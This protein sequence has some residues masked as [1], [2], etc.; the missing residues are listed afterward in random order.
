MPMLANGSPTDVKDFY[1]ASR[2]T[3]PMGISTSYVNDKLN[4]GR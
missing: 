4:A 1:I 3:G 2:I